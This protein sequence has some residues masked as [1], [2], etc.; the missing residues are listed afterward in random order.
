MQEK[1]K[2]DSESDVMSAFHNKK[3]DFIKVV[4]NKCCFFCFFFFK[5][6][7]VTYIQCRQKQT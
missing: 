5:A 2:I 6:V 3:F 1:S 7:I 4:E